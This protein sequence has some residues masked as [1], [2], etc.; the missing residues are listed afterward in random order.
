MLPQ[1]PWARDLVLPVEWPIQA[2][3]LIKQGK[4]KLHF[5]NQANPFFQRST[6]GGIQ[7]H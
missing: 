5:I 3:I 6:N 2:N 4:M 1:D 7:Q